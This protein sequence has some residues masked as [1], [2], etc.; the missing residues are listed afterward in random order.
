MCY[1][2]EVSFLMHNK[3]RLDHEEIRHLFKNWLRCFLRNADL[4]EATIRDHAL[5]KTYGHLLDHLQYGA[6]FC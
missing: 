6:S 2:N 4:A 3:I 5:E 1:H